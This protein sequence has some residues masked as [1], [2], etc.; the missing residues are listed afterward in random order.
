ME[1]KPPTVWLGRKTACPLSQ[2]FI[3]VFIYQV[4][5][6]RAIL[7]RFFISCTQRGWE[8][9][10]GESK[11]RRSGVPTE[12]ASAPVDLLWAADRAVHV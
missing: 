2:S 3:S 5:G 4:R 6:E 1:A 11:D 7:K 10:Q 12:E 8:A 9:K